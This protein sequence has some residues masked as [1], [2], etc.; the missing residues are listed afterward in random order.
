MT[1]H[2]QNR[3]VDAVFERL[4]VDGTFQGQGCKVL[5]S[6][7]EDEG[8]DFGGASRPVGRSSLLKVRVSEVTPIQ[9]GT[10][11]VDGQSH[12]VIARP[13]IKDRARLVWT[14]QVQ[15]G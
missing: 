10:F 2:L 12:K 8:I 7:D 6:R 13:M 4:G 3:A 9:G 11:E 14:C 15:P 5:F 1:W